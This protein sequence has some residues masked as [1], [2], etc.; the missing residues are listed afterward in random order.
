M[1]N[2]YIFQVSY[3]HDNST[4]LPYTAG[5]LIAYAKS[6]AELERYYDFREPLFIR[7]KDID[8][9][10]DGLD[11]PAVC[12]FS[13]YIWNH[14]YNKAVAKKIK[15]KFP[16]C[17]I[18]FGGHQ[19]TAG[20]ELIEN[21]DYI[22]FLLFGEGEIAFSNLLLALKNGESLEKVSSIAFK[23]GKEVKVTP[24]LAPQKELNYPSP[25]LN[26][27][28]DGI[29]E[30]YPQISF[31][32]LVET[33]RG[34]PYGC[35]YCDWG[36][37]FDGMNMR[38]FPEEKVIAE[39]EWISSRNIEMIIIC[40]SNF[41][42]FER[43]E[44]LIDKIVSLYKAG[45][46]IKKVQTSYAKNSNERVF[47]IT[48]KLTDCGM[49]KG[50]TISF[51]TL[52]DSALEN[53]HRRNIEIGAFS[54][55][56]NKYT[57]AKI[58]TYSELILGLPGETVESFVKGIDLLLNAGQHN[59]I[60]VHN[61][62]VLPLSPMGSRD[63]MLKHGIETVKI[64]LNQ[65]HCTIDDDEIIE[66][67]RLVVKTNS[68]SRDDWVDM[69]TYSSII[70]TFH[71]SGLL[72]F[73][74]LYLHCSE[75]VSYSAFYG[76]FRDWLISRP[77]TVAGG[78]LKVIRE[79][80]MAVT[81]GLSSPFFVD[82]RF[83]SIGWPP[84]EYL[85]LL[86]ICEWERFYD[87]VRE[88]LENYFDDAVLFEELLNF[89]KSSMKKPVQTPVRIESRYDFRQFFINI[90]KDE[91]QPLKKTRV[92]YRQDS[93]EA[94]ASLSEYA[95][96]VVWYGKKD[97][98]AYYLDS[99]DTVKRKH[100]YFVQANDIYG[101]GRPSVYFPYAVGC[102]M[103][104]LKQFP[105]IEDEYDFGRIIY[106]KEE[107]DRAIESLE[108]PYM[109]LFSCS[110]WNTEYNKAFARKIKER[111]PD[112]LVVFG[113]HSV[114]YD[115]RE[116]NEL[117]FV[118]YVIHGNGEEPLLGLLTA[119]KSGEDMADIP[120]IS[121]SG[122]GEVVTTAEVNQTGTDYPSP[123]LSGVFDDIMK[124]DISFSA[125]FETNRGCPNSCAFC[126]WSTL[127]SKV[128][129]FPLERVKK[130]IDW[131]AENKI[132]YIYCA[133]ANF[134]LFKRDEEIVNYIIKTKEKFG[135]PQVFKV[136]FTKNKLDF[137]FK[138][139]KK[140]HDHGLD[141]AQTISFQSMDPETLSNIGRK[142]ISAEQFRALMKRY[143]ESG[144]P[145]YC[146]LILGLPGEN[147]ESFTRGIASLIAD[148]QHHAMFIYP[149][150]VL[151]H[152]MMGQPWYKEKFKIKTV[153]IPFSLQHTSLLKSAQSV[154]EITEVV[155]G[156]Y[157]L[158]TEDWIKCMVFSY[159]VQAL[160]NLGLLRQT[161]I[162]C[163]NELNVPYDEFYSAVIEEGKDPK[164]AVLHA[165][166]SEVT[167]M[168]R[169]V[170]EGRHPLVMTC[171]GLG[172][173]LWAFDEGVYFKFYQKLD[174]FYEDIKRLIKTRFGDDGVIDEL[175]K[176]Q[177]AVVKKLGAQNIKIESEYDFYSYFNTVYMNS[178]EPLKKQKLIMEIKDIQPISDFSDYAR[179][180]IWY[181]R[182]KNK[183][184]YTSEFYTEKEIK[185]L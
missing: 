171:E 53:I 178:Y 151:P 169:A 91:Y 21:E 112:C 144:I 94:Y 138:T 161:A 64:P 175:I 182:N 77:K 102:L 69:N 2:V 167:A 83:G 117:G 38:F 172:D 72:I 101:A 61:C 5:A 133:D 45:G 170:S 22:D 60:Y 79:K 57:E 135:Y 87:E 139:G 42:M 103:A 155:T 67:S 166:V 19:L 76:A 10:V 47:S 154:T 145:T 95:K 84:E 39:L 108:D 27:I 80:F 7:E 136:N 74:A 99:F 173:T 1:K 153:R 116:I 142:N 105:E 73:F 31:H 176:Y 141:K 126:D 49:N 40:D 70:Q 124:D 50:T 23:D 68:M 11:E 35:A 132:E 14:E 51:Q 162:Y 137:V 18:V 97:S 58:P 106:K 36:G 33:N 168:I 125:L 140:F 122:N 110:V 93:P 8:R 118:D 174:G 181:G 115:G 66:Y 177:H 119:L 123:Y 85:F 17:T 78:A 75:G 152:A 121:F 13:N 28:F 150:E 104:Y 179:E 185:G 180:I 26:G 146:E 6:I 71:N 4:F 32:A 24:A 129:L 159:F 12:A 65:P 114:S 3:L 29:I 9:V 44:R 158:S 56:M 131:F 54:D 86:V 63:Y 184:D 82:R 16:S 120:N 128:R 147:Y 81:E 183:M 55:L 148:G 157:S 90:L 149:C 111:F 164:N 59:A 48:K 96:Y 107:I 62:E 30:H 134:C 130:E 143:R 43:D 109:I 37:G 20:T 52:C 88:F 160:H 165:V 15:A 41:G 163:A 156:T 113:G 89:Q 46:S 98:R 92:T 100:L 34:C 127:K 25:Y